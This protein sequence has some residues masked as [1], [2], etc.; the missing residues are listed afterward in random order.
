IDAPTTD[1]IL[2]SAER[3]ILPEFVVG[4]DFTWRKYDN[5]INQQ[6]L[7]FDD[8][9]CP[10]GGSDP[11]SPACINNVGRVN[12]PSD[13]TS[14]PVTL[15]MPDGSTRQVDVTGLRDGVTSRGG[16]Y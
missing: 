1:E 6:R 10:G 5:V 14:S 15:F 3:A 2:L 12:T 8:A 11:Y 13:Y 7:V 9:T 4:L 16:Y